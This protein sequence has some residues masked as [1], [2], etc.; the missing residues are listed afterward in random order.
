MEEFA[1]Q[2]VVGVI[3]AL[4]SAWVTVKLSLAK[5]RAEKWWERKIDAYTKV[6]EAFHYLKSFSD[7]HIHAEMR[8]HDL[9]EETDKEV[10]LK[11]RLAHQEID[12]YTDIGAFIF[13]TEFYKRLK[14][15]QRDSAKVSNDSVA[16]TDY[17][18]NDQEVT[19]TC[20]NDLIELAKIDLDSNKHNKSLN[21]I[22]AK[23]AP[24]G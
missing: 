15:F 1:K 17:L 6:F 8:G 7:N 12:K 24:S 22:G 2:I 3:I 13:S 19:E 10:R 14:Q 21:Q 20:L 11:S 16:W 18:I 4:C 9:P 5:F 23:N